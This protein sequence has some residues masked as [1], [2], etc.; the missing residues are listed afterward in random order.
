V[1]STA[2]SAA[3][4]RDGRPSFER[5]CRRVL[6]RDTAVSVTL[7]VFD[8][9]ELGGEPTLR[10]PYGERRAILESLE[11]GRG[12]HVCPRFDDGQ[13]LWASCSRAPA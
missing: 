12:C 5:V 10:L 11:F 4:G 9:L 8:V 6:Q 3:F 13:A 7:I 2:N 1:C